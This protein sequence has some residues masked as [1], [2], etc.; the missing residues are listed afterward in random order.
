MRKAFVFALMFLGALSAAP[1]EK[2][3]ANQSNAES[4]VVRSDVNL[5]STYFTVRDNHKQ[6]VSD[7]S[8]DRFRVIEDG[9]P[10]QIKFFAHHSD[11]LLNVG[12]MLDTGTNMAWI[13][14][15]EA[16]ASH[17]FMKHVVRPQ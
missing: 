17:L 5:V 4:P 1:Q 13:L 10:Q 15:R 11:V 8:Q 3:N 7:L 16:E 6:L 2:S 14:N 9:S 12:L